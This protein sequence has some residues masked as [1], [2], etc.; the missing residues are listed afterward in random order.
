MTDA[1]IDLPQLPPNETI[2][3][4]NLN[5]RVS[6]TA[7][8]RDLSA[9]FSKYNSKEVIAHKNIRMRGQAFI[10]FDQVKDA[11]KAMRDLQGYPF[12]EKPMLLQF[13]KAKSDR[14][15]QRID[16]ETFDAHKEKRLAAKIARGPLQP[17]TR[18]VATNKK[19]TK[20]QPGAKAAVP[21]DG[22]PPHKVLFI[23]N[24]P[25]EIT[26]DVMQ[27]IFAR[28]AGFKEVR[29]V[30]GRTGIAFVEYVDDDSAITA[31]EGTG[32]MTLS[33]QQLKVSYGKKV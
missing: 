31:R 16:P 27:A 29:M 28:Y 30:P 3:I 2:Y 19:T 25:E 11:E 32:G 12:E 8:K 14:T 33:G 23:Q 1:L 18:S 21:A 26:V 17:A 4:R 15:I 24:L 22:N 5:E 20:K 6:I 9:L 10:V 13:A 7:L